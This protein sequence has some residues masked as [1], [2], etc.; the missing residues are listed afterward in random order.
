MNTQIN[1]AENGTT[2]L[3]TAGKYC[4]RNIDVNVEVISDILYDADKV[5]D[6]TFSGEYVSD[7]VI[8]VKESAFDKCT[9]IT[10]VS[11]PNCISI[12]KCAFRDCSAL[13]NVNLPSCETFFQNDGASYFD[14]AANLKSI[15]IPNLTTMEIGSRAFAGCRVL[16]E[17][18]APNLTS[19]A[20][21]QN[22]MFHVCVSLKK[23]SLPKLGGA[24]LSKSI[25]N[26]CYRLKT[27]ILGGNQLNTL[28]GA[29]TAGSVAEGTCIFYVPD[30]LV[31]T[32]KTATNW[33]AYANQIKPISELEE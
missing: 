18:N 31:D 5:V 12:A 9:N 33:A 1:I 20:A 6:G 29:F 17:F 22:N 14:G 25:F 10:S 21:H 19:I 16:E 26:N 11:L 8:N 15:N 27:V 24:S 28:E 4:D 7:K 32:Y 3:A 13:E 23:V 2:T 30:D